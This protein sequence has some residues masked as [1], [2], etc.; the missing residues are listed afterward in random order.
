MASITGTTSYPNGVA[1]WVRDCYDLNDCTFTVNGVTYDVSY[2]GDYAV[3]YVGRKGGWNSFLFEGVSKKVDQLTDYKYNRVV[4]N[5]SID[6]ENNKYMVEINPTYELKTG[7]LSDE[8][9]ELFARDII[10]TPKMYLHKLIENEIVPALVMDS[11][12]EYKTFKNQGRKFVQYTLT[13]QESQT[14]YRK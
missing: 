6:F 13:V 1:T 11:S 9:A 5:T 12:A 4:N 7:W 14:K 8:E 3:Y 10:S 2:C